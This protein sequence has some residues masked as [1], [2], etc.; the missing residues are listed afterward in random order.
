[1]AEESLFEK[2]I[3]YHHP[4][5]IPVSI[6]IMPSLWK[7]RPKEMRDLTSRY[8]QFFGDMGERY[9]YE[10]ALPASY[11]TGSF[12][13]EWGCVWSNVQEGHEA[14]VTGHPVKTREDIRTLKIPD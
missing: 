14:I 12:T 11:H 6:G 9:D 8:P 5:T 3:N 2:A 1:M 7:A 4:E 10:Q 13:D